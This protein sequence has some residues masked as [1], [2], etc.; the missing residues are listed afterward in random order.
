MYKVPFVLQ[1]HMSK[2][3]AGKHMDLRIKY[4]EANR[5]ASWAI[6]NAILPEEKKKVL[7]IRTPDHAI[8]WLRF[9]GYIS[10]KYGRGTVTIVDS[11]YVNVIAW[12]SKMIT[13]TAENE[14][15]NGKY[16]LIKYKKLGKSDSWLFIKSS[17][18]EKKS[19]AESW[20]IM[21]GSK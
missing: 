6:P 12:S 19:V 4:Q 14:V 9:E 18:K 2:G 15:L 21:R 3:R 16:T 1:L 17:D 11:G 13:F 5:L 20:M 10:E 8:K 7:A